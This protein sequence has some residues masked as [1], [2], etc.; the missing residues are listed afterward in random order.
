MIIWKII[1]WALVI[2]TV[3]QLLVLPSSQITL[4]NI[5]LPLYTA[6]ILIPM[7]GY[8]YST[9]IGLRIIAIIILFLN[10]AAVIS[11]IASV[12]FVVVSGYPLSEL[13]SG[14][15]LLAFLLLPTFPIYSYAY[16]SKGL[17]LK[18]A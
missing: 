15:I 12:L 18:N 1:F 7:Y 10:L 2:I 13:S 9:R 8:C 16:K 3:G 5:L 17:W 11:C 14:L 6:I 4:V